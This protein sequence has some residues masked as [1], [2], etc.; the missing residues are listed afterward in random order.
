MSEYLTDD[1]WIQ[2]IEKRHFQLSTIHSQLIIG[3]LR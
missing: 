1:R 3:R 2:E